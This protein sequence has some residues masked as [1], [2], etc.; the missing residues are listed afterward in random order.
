MKTEYKT[1][2]VTTLKGLKAAERLKNAGWIML[3]VGLFT[4]QFY[5]KVK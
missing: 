4:I 1:I 2:D 3:R 5:R